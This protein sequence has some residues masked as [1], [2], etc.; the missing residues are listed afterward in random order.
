MW[1]CISICSIV[2]QLASIIG[3]CIKKNE[4]R[5]E[6]RTSIRH[7]GGWW[8]RAS[9]RLTSDFTALYLVCAHISTPHATSFPLCAPPDINF[10]LRLLTPTPAHGK[11]PC[12]RNGRRHGSPRAPAD[13]ILDRINSPILPS[14]AFLSLPSASRY[15]RER[16][17]ER[18][19]FI[20]SPVLFVSTHTISL[21][22]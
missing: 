17:Y 9:D 1:R 15:P 10:Q 8:S 18:T 11:S 16:P 14:Y 19:V 12:A 22:A 5:A 4:W 20:K 21:P 6:L 3:M 13:V 7:R 2:V